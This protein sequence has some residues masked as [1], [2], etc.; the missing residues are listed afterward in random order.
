MSSSSSSSSLWVSLCVSL[1]FLGH[2]ISGLHPPPCGASPALLMS[3]SALVAMKIFDHPSEIVR[4]RGFTQPHRHAGKA[5]SS[6]DA[7]S[8]ASLSSL[9]S[10]M[11]K[12]KTGADELNVKCYAPQT[13]P[14][15]PKST[16]KFTAQQ[17]PTKLNFVNK[18]QNKF[19]IW[20]Q[21]FIKKTQE[22]W[23]I[24]RKHCLTPRNWPW[25]TLRYRVD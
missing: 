10:C 8:S 1:S 25:S 21:W 11:R 22:N 2:Q 12:K 17:K 7:H 4:Q 24:S 6:S 15:T 3:T 23:I 19:E 13:W 16:K 14:K 20:N 5:G 9:K 18:K